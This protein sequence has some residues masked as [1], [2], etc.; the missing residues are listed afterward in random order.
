MSGEYA[1]ERPSTDDLLYPGMA[2]A[3]ENRLPD[4]KDLE[5]LIDVEIR[6]PIC[7]VGIEE[8]GTAK[9]WSRIGIPAMCPGV[10][11]INR[12]ASRELM[13]DPGQ[14]HVVVGFALA[15]ED[16][17]AVDQGIERRALDDSETV[18]II[19]EQ[20]VMAGAAQVAQARDP[21]MA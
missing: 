4:T 1:A 2:A 13:P 19:V 15:A 5:R 17:D 10:L 14:H 11:H 3:K 16:V 21:G 6:P 20:K 12:E 7:I 8:I 9:V 18:R